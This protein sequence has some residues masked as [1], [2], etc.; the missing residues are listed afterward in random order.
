MFKLDKLFGNKHESREA[1]L[2]KLKEGEAG[3]MNKF[4]GSK[5]R[6]SLMFL[7]AASLFVA[8]TGRAEASET[9]MWD[10]MQKMEDSM[11]GFKMEDMEKVFKVDKSP[12][13]NIAVEDK[14]NRYSSDS[15]IEIDNAEMQASAKRQ[16][17]EVRKSIHVDGLDS[18]DGP[19]DVLE[20]M[21]LTNNGTIKQI[22]NGSISL[23]DYLQKVADAKGS[24]LTDQEIH[25]IETNFDNVKNAKNPNSTRAFQ[26]ALEGRVR[27]VLNIK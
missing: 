1:V 6:T 13:A 17:E 22:K 9:D 26:R 20:A 15:T 18:E 10:E 24:S 25:S 27:V 11:P 12:E 5:A 7:M 8:K 14:S 19:G 2:D 4:R 16:L 3:L 23:D 21:K